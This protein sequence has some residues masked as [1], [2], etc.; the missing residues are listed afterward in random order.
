MDVLKEQGK[1][2]A[3]ID[4]YIGN[5]KFVSSVHHALSKY[6]NDDIDKSGVTDADIVSNNAKV[7][8]NEV[9]KVIIC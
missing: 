3:E 6:K 1:T 2:D 5:Q 8:T 7:V 9:F 4:Q